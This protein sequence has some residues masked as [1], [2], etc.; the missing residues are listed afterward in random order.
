MT[1][2]GSGIPLSGVNVYAFS[3]AGS[4][5]GIDGTTN[6]SGKVGFHP[7]GRVIQIPGRLSGQSILE[8]RGAYRC[9]TN[10][11][12][13]HIDRR[14]I[15]WLDRPKRRFRSSGRSELLRVQ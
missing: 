14:R 1:V 6:P 2:T 13:R 15:V 3:G 7:S 12:R 11:S 8:Q 10:Q 4:Y 5:L 9:R